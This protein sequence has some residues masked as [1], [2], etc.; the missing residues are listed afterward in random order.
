MS[1][2]KALCDQ[3]DQSY[4]FRV[5]G[6]QLINCNK[7]QIFPGAI[8]EWRNASVLQFKNRC[9]KD[10]LCPMGDLPRTLQK[11]SQRLGCQKNVTM[12]SD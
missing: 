2:E 7:N 5:L 9:I 10:L 4:Y 11:D 3:C 8:R 1:H 6:E 12:F